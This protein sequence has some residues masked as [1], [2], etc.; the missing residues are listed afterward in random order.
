VPFAV[1]TA[2][3]T[4][5]TGAEAF[6]N[7]AVTPGTRA[8]AERVAVR[9]EDEIDARAPDERGARVTVTLADGA[10]ASAAVR[11]A[12]GGEADPFEPTE[13]RAKFESLVAPTIGSER[14]DQLWTAARDLAPPR[15]LCARVR[16]G[17]HPDR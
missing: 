17:E 14:T 13:L 2:L 8:L 10:E 15:V 16:G 1:A 11:H 5:S 6:T 3:R 4:G 7:D 9:V 12:R